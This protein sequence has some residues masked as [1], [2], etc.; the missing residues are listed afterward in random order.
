MILAKQ[1]IGQLDNILEY[2]IKVMDFSET[3]LVL[4]FC[5]RF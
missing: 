1:I 2:K 4:E 3:F 5:V